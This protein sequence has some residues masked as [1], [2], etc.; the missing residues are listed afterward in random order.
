MSNKTLSTTFKVVDQATATIK[1]IQRSFSGLGS[2]AQKNAD[3]ASKS[4]SGLQ[5]TLST[6]KSPKDAFKGISTNISEIMNKLPG[7]QSLINALGGG[8]G[9]LLSK[10]KAILVTIGDIS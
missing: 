3:R 1:K 2:E 4:F 9:A 5:K 8:A 7:M 10:F 6:L